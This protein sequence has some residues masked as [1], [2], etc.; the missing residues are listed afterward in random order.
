MS[1]ITNIHY[2]LIISKYSSRLI[3]TIDFPFK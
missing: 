3:I 2:F 1:H